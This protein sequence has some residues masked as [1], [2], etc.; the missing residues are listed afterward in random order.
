LNVYALQAW[1]FDEA[2]VQTAALFA[3]QASIV[4]GN[5]EAFTRAQVTVVS[6]EQ[7]LTSRSVID[8]AKG[9]V[10]A[11]EGC[12]PSQA[13]DVLRQMSQTQH[14]KLRDIAHELIDQVQREA[15][16]TAAEP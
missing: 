3:E 11:R 15:D 13:F 4:L 2:T 9:I 6:L 10:M 7:A 8:T 16:E 14:R 12:G 5:A 1:V